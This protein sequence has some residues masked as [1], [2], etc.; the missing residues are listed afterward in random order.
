MAKK[1]YSIEVQVAS[2]LRKNLG[3]KMDVGIIATQLGISENMVNQGLHYIRKNVHLSNES[4]IKSGSY[5]NS[6]YELQD[7]NYTLHDDIQ[8]KMDA[9]TKNL[10]RMFIDWTKTAK[11]ANAT[12]NPVKRTQLNKIVATKMAE[13]TVGMTLAAQ[14]QLPTTNI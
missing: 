9:N 14:L 1:I 2:L 5:G 11:L 6:K 3:K 8:N 10:L 12:T 4:I 7:D 13:I